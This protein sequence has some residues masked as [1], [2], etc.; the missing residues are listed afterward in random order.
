MNKTQYV[1]EHVSDET[2]LEVQY[3]FEQFGIDVS[4][5]DITEMFNPDRFRPKAST[6]RPSMASLSLR[7]PVD[8][9]AL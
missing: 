3:V 9:H 7:D 6:I 8:H 2:V 5:V 4:G 1:C